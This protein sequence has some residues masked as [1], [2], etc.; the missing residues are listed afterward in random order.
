LEF[1]GC[2]SQ[3]IFCTSDWVKLSHFSTQAVHA[4]KWALAEFAVGLKCHPYMLP[5]PA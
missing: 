2:F 3:A 5:L 4:S 1:S